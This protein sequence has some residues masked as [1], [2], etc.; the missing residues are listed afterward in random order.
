[1][2]GHRLLAWMAIAALAVTTTAVQAQGPEVRQATL[3]PARGYMPA[4]WDGSG[5]AYLFGGLAT[6]NVL[7][8][9]IVRYSPADDRLEVMDARLPF[10][11]Y[12]ASAVWDGQ[13]HAYIF[14]GRTSMAPEPVVP[15][16]DPRQ[17]NQILRY[18]PETGLLEPMPTVLPTPRY[19]MA[20]VWDGD[21]HA[22]LF[23]GYDGN[24]LED[25]VQYTPATG[26]I[27]TLEARL[28]GP[29]SHLAAVWDP[30]GQ[31]LLFGG[32]RGSGR[33]SDEILR[34]EAAAGTVIE[35]GARLPERTESMSAVW[36]GDRALVFG[37]G[38][39]SGQSDAIVA[40]Y[41]ATSQLEAMGVLPSARAATSAVWDP[42]G[43][44]YV[45]GGTQT[46]GM[47]DD[48]LAFALGPAT[49]GTV[50]EP[51]PEAGLY[52][53]PE[54]GSADPEDEPAPDEGVPRL[55]PAL[56]AAMLMLA[57]AV[58]LAVVRRR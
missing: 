14:G 38:A 27:A 7:L 3:E 37:G 42:A 10:P 57:L 21:G 6:G 55:V 15:G 9:Q 36:S 32:Y 30:A 1:M 23:G 16:V 18:T 24:H 8:D 49:R 41:P 52:E 5:H 4:V 12:G 48:V 2:L 39:R 44:A 17:S 34:F 43:A 54:D 33:Y 47:Q 28:P 13:G 50:I 35:T 22:Y 46:N 40:Y 31:A 11:V 45:F 20:A 26:A 53:G 19:L 56:P 25:I 58:V 51:R 29:H